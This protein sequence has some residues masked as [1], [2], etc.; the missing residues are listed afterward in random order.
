MLCCGKT[1]QKKLCEA[2]N[3]SLLEPKEGLWWQDVGVQLEGFL[4]TEGLCNPSRHSWRDSGS[5][6][7]APFGTARVGPAASDQTRWQALSKE[8][9]PLNEDIKPAFITQWGPIVRAQ[10]GSFRKARYEKEKEKKVWG[11][12]NGSGRMWSGRRGGGEERENLRRD[13]VRELINLMNGW[14]GRVV[15]RG[16]NLFGPLPSTPVWVRP[17]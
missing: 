11:G 1:K 15:C 3:L 14:I 2:L 9:S 17:H 10:M 16:R 8:S 12:G 5:G 6:R 7:Q 13:W 4:F